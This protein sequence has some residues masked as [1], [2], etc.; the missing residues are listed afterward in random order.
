MDVKQVPSMTRRITLLHPQLAN[1]IAAGEVIERP[2]SV[3]KELLENSLDAGASEIE[4]SIEGGGIQRICIRDN[5]SGIQ[6]DDLALALSRHATSKISSLEELEQVK[7][8]GF[9][10]EALASIASVSRLTLASRPKEA[11]TAWQLRVEGRDPEIDIQPVAHPPGTTMDVRDLFFN[12]PA[13]RKFLRTEKTENTHIHD[14]ITQ[15]ALSC[16]PVGFTLKNGQKT[17]LHLPAAHTLAEK[18]QRVAKICGEAFMQSALAL[19]IETFGLT[20]TGWIALPSFMRSQPDMQHV[21]VNGRMVRDKLITHA[22][23]QAYKD[24]QYGNHHPAYVLY[25][26][27]DPVMVDVNVHPSKNEVRFRESRQVH[28]FIFKSIHHALADAGPSQ[29]ASLPFAEI[30]Q[31][32]LEKENLPANP[33]DFSIAEN[34]HKKS[35]QNSPVS[36]TPYQQ[37]L[38]LIAREQTAIY[39]HLAEDGKALIAQL[40]LEER[41]SPLSETML[42]SALEEEERAPKSTPCT[43]E[44]PIPP[45]G[46]ALGQLHGIYILAENAKGLVIVDMHAAHERI[47]YEKLKTDYAAGKIETQ[48]SCVPLTFSLTEKEAEHMLEHQSAFSEL[49]MGIEQIAPTTFAI[50]HSPVLFKKIDMVQLTRDLLSDWIAEENSHRAEHTLHTLLGNIACRSAKQAHHHLS[51]PEMNALLRDMEKTDRSGQC[52][53]GRPTCREFSIKELDRFFLRGR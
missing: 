44:S 4:I 1:Q 47:L 53:H 28:D 34:L 36:F 42:P 20:L 39:Q 26:H 21:Y 38:P 11:S 5:G 13:R 52:N 9:R 3:V 6:K 29:A 49:G 27:L 50:R 23:R 30:E 46:Y 7:S 19:E 48:T 22:I 40:H 10:G 2:A 31:P 15:I 51:L 16:F 43:E 41:D 45:L 24:V 37:A 8:L 33:T 18:E 12:T 14:R 32:P 25:L 17:T 35:A